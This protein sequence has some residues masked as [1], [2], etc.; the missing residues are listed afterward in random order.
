MWGLRGGRHRIKIFLSSKHAVYLPFIPRG[1]NKGG[2]A[3]RGDKRETSAG[4][5]K[6]ARETKSGVKWGENE[7]KRNI[8]VLLAL[9]LWT[10]FSSGTQTGGG[11]GMERGM[12]ERKEGEDGG[13]A[14][15][16]LWLLVGLSL[17]KGRRRIPI[18]L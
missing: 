9:S 10:G 3:E 11:G 13:K 2:S 6:R 16:V 7:R 4:R 1:R 12:R 8:L 5:Q 15:E 17:T 14:R 18:L